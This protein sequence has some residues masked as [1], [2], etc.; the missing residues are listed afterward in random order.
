[1]NNVEE[2]LKEKDIQYSNAGKDVLVLCFN[3]EHEDSSPSTRI[4]KVTGVFH[5]FSCGYRGNVFELFNKLRDHRS[6]AVFTIKKKIRHIVTSTIGLNIP[7]GAVPYRREFRELKASTVIHAEA[8][9]HSDYEDRL[10]FPIKNIAGRIVAFSARHMYSDASPK[11]IVYPDEAQ[12]PIYPGDARPYMGSMIL[13]EGI[14]DALNLIDKGLTNV[15]CLFGT[16]SLSHANVV[17]RLNPLILTGTKHIYL[18]LDGDK[19]GKTA[20]EDIKKIINY[21]TNLIVEPMYL[22]DGQDPGALDQQAVDYLKGK[23]Y[24]KEL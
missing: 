11:Y 13:V 20:T 8:F 7:E 15:G 6:E 14:M 5:C 18:M 1:M 12:L 3:P 19:A 24:D 22:E 23:M 17:E 2:V 16:H 9:T 10:V 21:K 4:D